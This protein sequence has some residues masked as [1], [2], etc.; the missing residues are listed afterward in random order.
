MQSKWRRNLAIIMVA[1]ATIAACC[2]AYPAY[3]FF[4]DPAFTNRPFNST[5]WKEG[6]PR[7]RGEMVESLRAQA[8]LLGKSEAE[9]QA[10]LGPPWGASL[11]GMC[12]SVDLG[13]RIAW[14]P[15]SGTLFL[16]FDQNG[17]VSGVEIWYDL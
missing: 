5:A 7:S 11:K 1:I 9:V 12:Y 10:L 8:L 4:R 6:G 2:L 16:S 3:R 17:R 13:Q 15:L 14:E